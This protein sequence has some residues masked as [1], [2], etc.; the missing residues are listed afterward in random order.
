[1]PHGTMQHNTYT[2]PSEIY[3]TNRT[4]TLTGYSVP[5]PAGDPKSE[6]ASS[7]SRLILPYSAF[8]PSSPLPQMNLHT[9]Y[10]KKLETP[11]SSNPTTTAARAH[12]RAFAK[13]ARRTTVSS[14]GATEIIVS[15][16]RTD[17]QTHTHTRAQ[18]ARDGDGP[19]TCAPK[20]RAASARIHGRLPE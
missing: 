1:M 11:N 12:T 16:A 3:A 2:I 19:R 14:Q 17:R 7:S 9:L 13:K 8:R 10:T 4:V 20:I 18:T 15:R 5:A 6:S